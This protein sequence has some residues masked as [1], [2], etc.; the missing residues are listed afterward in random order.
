MKLTAIIHVKNGEKYIYENINSL[1]NALKNI[2]SEI[3]VSDNNS[4][5]DTIDII[6]KNFPSVNIINSFSE[7]SQQVNDAVKMAKGKYI[8]LTAAD[9]LYNDVYFDEAINLCENNN[10]D[11]VFTSVITAKQDTIIDKIKAHERELYIGD[12]FHETA[13][14]LNKKAFESIGG[15]NKEL[16]AGEDYDFQRRFN[17]AGYKTGRVKTYAEKHL[18]EEVGWS[19]V[20]KRS[21]YMGKSLPNF[22]RENKIKGVIQMSPFRKN[23]LNKK[24]ISKPFLLLGI[25]VYKF[26]QIIGA[27]FGMV[28]F[29]VNKK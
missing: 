1:R 26:V 19:G 12:D 15:Y 10:F 27:F 9:I 4:T 17:E 16:I 22:F 8:Y 29:Y 5:D 2:E 13:R 18:D 7:R 21:Y 14:F 25:F 24:A 11:G 28:D 23:Y 3:L 6:K 20:Y